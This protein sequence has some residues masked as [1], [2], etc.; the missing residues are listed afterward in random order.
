MARQKEGRFKTEVHTELKQRFPGIDIIGGNSAM[1]QGIPDTLLQWQG[2]HA[3]LEFKKSEG[4]EKQP[5]QDYY[6]GKFNNEGTFSS[7]IYPENKEEVLNALE[8]AWKA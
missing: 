1:R 5:N 7:F 8:R 6:V 2:R 3:W 4:A